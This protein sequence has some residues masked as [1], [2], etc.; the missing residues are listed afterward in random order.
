MDE[1]QTGSGDVPPGAGGAPN[2]RAA[3]AR[4]LEN[5]VLR[6]AGHVPAWL[7]P[8]QGEA[9]WPVLT[10]LAA[11]LAAQLLLPERLSIGPSWLLPS[12]EGALILGLTA[13]NPVRL[14]RDS[15]SIRR[16]SLLL[17][18]V[19]SLANAGS[20]VLLL[21]G[22][23][24]GDLVGGAPTLL[25]GG[26]EVYLTNIVAFAL[27]YWELDRGGPMARATVRRSQPDF[28][29]PQMATPAVASPAWTPTFPDYLYLSF[30]NA[31]AFSPTDTMPLSRW[32]KMLM[33]IQSAVALVTA[34][35][36]VARAV[37][38]FK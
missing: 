29:F 32:A 23:I 27:W 18:A 31:T 22:L 10:A 21:H 37:N 17:V 14:S 3:A 11:A 8:S 30:T 19:M 15:V 12:V 1:G 35:L 28:L 4:R 2:E 38:I 36:V 34:A 26:G 20:A 25:A 33:L 6:E 24:A 16:T 7:R 9:R 5:W 13:A